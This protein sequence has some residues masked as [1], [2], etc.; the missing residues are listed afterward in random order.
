MTHQLG[1]A[2][3]EKVNRKAQKDR[4]GEIDQKDQLDAFELFAHS[5]SEFSSAD[6]TVPF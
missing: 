4:E 3:I 1:A 5:S 6:S 2:F